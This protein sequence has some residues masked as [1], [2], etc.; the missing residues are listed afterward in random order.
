MSLKG[1]WRR[2]ENEEPPGEILLAKV[3]EGRKRGTRERMLVDDIA[4]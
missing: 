1:R 2:D 4:N 3:W